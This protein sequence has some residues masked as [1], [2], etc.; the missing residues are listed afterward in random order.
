LFE[1]DNRGFALLSCHFIYSATVANAVVRVLFRDEAV[2]S[3]TADGASKLQISDTLQARESSVRKHLEEH[4]MG[5]VSSMLQAV[6][7]LGQRLNVQAMLIGSVDIVGEGRVGSTSF[8]EVAITLRL[9]EAQSGMILWQSSGRES[10][11]SLKNR[12][13]GLS[14]KDSFQITNDLVRGMIATLPSV[15]E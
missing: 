5:S 10:G 1:P 9:L 15:E 8:P 14:P 12:I 4:H 2:V 6:K 3:V 7:R 11:E 13:L